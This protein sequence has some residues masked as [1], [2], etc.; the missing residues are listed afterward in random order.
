METFDGQLRQNRFYSTMV[1][2]ATFGIFLSIGNAWSSFLE[3]VAKAVTPGS[4][5]VLVEQFVFAVTNSMVNII[6]IA[7]LI[8]IDQKI[9]DAQN[10][11][12]HNITNGIMSGVTRT[13]TTIASMTER[14]RQTER[15]R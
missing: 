10:M 4:N 7:C 3:E 15:N 8:K 2:G 14:A 12:V 5:N 13:N 11:N 9:E 1:T 6:I